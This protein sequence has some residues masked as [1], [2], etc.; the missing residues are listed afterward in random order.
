MAKI[1]GLDLGTNSI[2]WAIRDTN[3]KGNQILD[4]NVIV[5]PKGVGEKEGKEF[6]MASERTKNRAKR[7]LYKRRKKRKTDLLKLLIENGFCPLTIDEL[8]IWSEYKKGQEMKYP[9]TNFEFTEWLK[10]NPY[11]VR[12]KAVNQIVSKKELG[13]ALYHMCQRRGFKSGRKDADAGKDFE[14][15]KKEQEILAQSGFKTLGE[16][17]Y[18]LL[19]ND[20]KVRKTKFS[21]DDQEVNSSRI[22][23]VEEFNILMKA[24]NI[25]KELSDAFFDAIFFQR[26][27]KS[28]KGAV[29]KCTLEKTK[30]RC[31]ISHPL[32]EEFRMYQYLNSIK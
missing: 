22:S 32:F 20:K 17:Y 4:S 9:A 14:Q 28:Q 24:Q 19:Q 1:L 25:S 31:A 12:A 3:K 29:G 27:L 11:E 5:F 26:P 18:D 8:T 21:A 10:I 2:G 7:K 6:S 13:R 15:Y 23:Y 30:T 16:Y